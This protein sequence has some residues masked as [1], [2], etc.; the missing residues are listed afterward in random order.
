MKV[1]NKEIIKEDGGSLSVFY[2]YIHGHDGEIPFFEAC[3]YGNETIIKYLVEQGADINKKYNLND[4]T[5]LFDFCKE[6]YKSMI[7]YLVEHGTDINER[8]HHGETP[9]FQAC[10]MKMRLWQ[11]F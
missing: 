9:L 6:E 2:R 8:N 5:L 10:C 11:N 7:K 1:I 3:R 4:E